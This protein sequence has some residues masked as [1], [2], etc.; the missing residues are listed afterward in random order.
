MV[1][2]DVGLDEIKQRIAEGETLLK[3]TES[4]KKHGKPLPGSFKLANRI[5]SE[6][7]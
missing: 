6:L 1:D 2:S 5:R 7:K 4:L 3:D